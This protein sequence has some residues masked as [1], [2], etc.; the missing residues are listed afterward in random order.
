MKQKLTE[1]MERYGK[2]AVY[3]YL[4]IFFVTFFSIL[5]LVQSGVEL[6]QVSWFQEGL[7]GQA[8]TLTIAYLV[9]KILQPVRIGLML[10]LLPLFGRRAAPAS[11][12]E[13]TSE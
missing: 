10:L 5:L 4:A 3:L 7:A 1:V 6:Q 12:E 8:G 9:T 13:T 2:I 11:T